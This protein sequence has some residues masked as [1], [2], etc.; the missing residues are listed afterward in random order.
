MLTPGKKSPTACGAVAPRPASSSAST[1]CWHVCTCS[2]LP[3]SGGRGALQAAGSVA[4]EGLFPLG[5]EEDGHFEVQAAAPRPSSVI[6]AT[7]AI[8][9][10]MGEPCVSSA[11][12]ACAPSDRFIVCLPLLLGC[13][14][15][16]SR[17]LRVKLVQPGFP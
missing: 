7:S 15:R 1:R 5:V 2:H 4:T 3:T 16:R 12:A 14:L 13:D 9:C 10:L 17:L 6:T 11:G 8:G